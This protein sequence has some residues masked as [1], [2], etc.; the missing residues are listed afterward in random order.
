MTKAMLTALVITCLV[1]AGRANSLASRS[2][3]GRTRDADRIPSN[4]GW[5]RP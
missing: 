1:Y 5:P 4:K 2:I 3:A